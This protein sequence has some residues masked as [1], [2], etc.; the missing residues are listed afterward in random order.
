MK[1]IVS[2]ILIIFLMT[3]FS[4]CAGNEL[5]DPNISLLNQ[6]PN[7]TVTESVSDSAPEQESTKPEDV[8]QDAAKLLYMG[9]A[10]I[11][12]TTKEGKVIY[13][14]PYAGDGYEPTADLIL[15]THSHYDHNGI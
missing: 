9:Q 3:L 13:I 4:A 7:A 11:R 15:V 5:S 12:I 6:E 14:D 10:S 8:S 2:V 1:R